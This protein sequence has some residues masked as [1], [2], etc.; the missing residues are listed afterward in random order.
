MSVGTLGILDVA[1]VGEEKTAV[2]LLYRK[3]NC[4]IAITSAV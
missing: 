1:I 4:Y 2:L 3:K